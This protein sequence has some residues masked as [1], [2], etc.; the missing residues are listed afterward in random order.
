VDGTGSRSYTMASFG[1]NS[2]EPLGS[3]ANVY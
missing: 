2:V 1:I 3:A